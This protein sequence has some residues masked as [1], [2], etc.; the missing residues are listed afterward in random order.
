MTT[1][2][3]IGEFSRLCHLSAKTLR[4][5]HDISLLVPAFQFT[6]DTKIRIG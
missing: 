4:Y 2:V 1:G 6:S 5:Y 3:T